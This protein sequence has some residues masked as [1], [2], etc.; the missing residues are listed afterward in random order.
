MTA[1]CWSPREE[2]LAGIEA[3]TDFTRDF[4][5][6]FVPV[7]LQTSLAH[8]YTVDNQRVQL[9]LATIADRAGPAARV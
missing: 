2:E 7:L 5:S 3:A 9:L 6:V 4:E 1:Q 8:G